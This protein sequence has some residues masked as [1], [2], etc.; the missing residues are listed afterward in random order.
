MPNRASEGISREWGICFVMW[1][2][3][4]GYEGETIPRLLPPGEYPRHI[5]STQR[6]SDRG[7]GDCLRRA[8]QIPSCHNPS[9]TTGSDPGPTQTSQRTCVSQ[10]IRNASIRQT[11]L[12]APAFQRALRQ[13][14]A[15]VDLDALSHLKELR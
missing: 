1:L 10:E 6:S 5:R 4:V 7:E 11:L 12:W 14:W 15:V 9:P 2:G 13:V 8:P 3:V